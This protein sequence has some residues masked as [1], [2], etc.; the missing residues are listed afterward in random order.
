MLRNAAFGPFHGS[1]L[2]NITTAE[3]DAQDLAFNPLSSLQ[4]L[5][6]AR[7]LR[8]KTGHGTL[9]SDLL[10]L[11]SAVDFDNFDFDRIKPLLNAIL[12]NKLDKDIWDAV[13]DAVT[14]S[15]PPPWPIASSLQQTPWLRNI[16]S[17][18]N[19]SEH[20][21]YMN[22]ALKEELGPI[23]S[24][25]ESLRAPI[26]RHSLQGFTIC[27]SLMR[28]WE[29]DRLG[30]IASE[31]FDINEDGLQFVSTIL[32]FLWINEE[33]LGFDPT[34]I[35]EDSRSFVTIKRKGQTER[36]VIDESTKSEVVLPYHFVL[37]ILK[38]LRRFKHGSFVEQ[39]ELSGE[40]MLDDETLA[41]DSAPV[42]WWDLFKAIGETIGKTFAASEVAS[43]S[44][45]AAGFVNWS[46]EKAQVYLAELRKELKALTI[47]SYLYLRVIYVQKPKV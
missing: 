22:D 42:R 25:L 27:K 1:R 21:G 3:A 13:Y 20:R 24:Y 2:E 29:F 7:H 46:L 47:Y 35:K 34:I 6:A 10:R 31:K 32:A 5:P 4:I 19:S 43:E 36:L 26:R 8:S 40:A 17:F 14:E 41:Q 45:A 30:G 38:R 11:N 28:I 18:A 9:R 33:E 44:I 37:V 12:A 39:V 23:F 15:T 16:S